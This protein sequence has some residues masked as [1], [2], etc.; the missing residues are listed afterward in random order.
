MK[1]FIIIIDWFGNK[2]YMNLITAQIIKKNQ[3]KKELRNILE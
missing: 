3:P 2:Y 1:Y